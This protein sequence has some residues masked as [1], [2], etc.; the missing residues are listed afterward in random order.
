MIDFWI[1]ATPLLLAASA[2]L[3]IPLWRGMRPQAEEDRTALNVALYQEHL[4]ALAEQRAAGTLSEIQWTT[5]CTEATRELL[6][7]TQPQ[8]CRQRRL[9]WW[10]PM[11]LAVSIPVIAI[12]LYTHW[13]SQEQL[14]L[15]REMATPPA[16]LEDQ[17][18]RLE[19][20]TQ[21]QPDVGTAWYV[22]GRSY[23]AQNRPADAVYPFEQA[24]RLLGRQPELLG[25]LIQARYFAA[26][27]PNRWSPALQ[28]LADEALQ[29]DPKEPTT[30]GLLGVSAFEGRRF[31]E[32][33]GFWSRL[34]AQIPT[35]DSAYRS[36]QAG[37]ER[38]KAESSAQEPLNTSP[39]LQVQL[40]ISLAPEV[41]AATQ[42][43]D[44][45]FVFA[46][47]TSGLPMPMPLAVKRL[48]VAD[49]PTLVT[50]SD[51]D[52]MLPQLRLSGFDQVRFVVRISKTGNARQGEWKA[53]H[54]VIDPK[55]ITMPLTL[56][57]SQ[58]EQPEITGH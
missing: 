26:S 29:G 27:G 8:P 56:H 40:A 41:Q 23:M 5:A 7:D 3:F 6:A 49:L 35:T 50:L 34:L 37:I 16:S 13:G 25:Q 47:A 42:P 33:I 1:A 46:Q 21:L 44:S 11:G 9:G 45:V 20:A 52:A 38:A 54:A 58:P 53:E 30:L 36:I 14:A 12:Q 15:A 57:I 48:R 24:I 2:F 51:A 4:A 32:A 10:I 22:L 17:I 19:R 28:Q 18:H 43:E 39:S 31:Q 55:T